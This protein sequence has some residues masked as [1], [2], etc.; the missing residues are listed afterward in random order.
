MTTDDRVYFVLLLR[1]LALRTT[2]A[3]E[4]RGAARAAAARM[5]ASED[6]VARLLKA[7]DGDD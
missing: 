5:E 6:S 2:L 4:V 3:P 7:I 1:L